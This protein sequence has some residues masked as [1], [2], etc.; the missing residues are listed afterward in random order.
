MAANVFFSLFLAKILT[1]FKPNCVR[2]SPNCQDW[3][4]LVFQGHSD[5]Q[6]HT[7]LEGRP[8]V[9]GQRPTTDLLNSA[10]FGCSEENQVAQEGILNWFIVSCTCLHVCMAAFQSRSPHRGKDFW[11]HRAQNKIKVFYKDLS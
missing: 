11:A 3:L 10:E 5:Q 4:I 1:K 8:I 9:M 7:R 6:R 2:S